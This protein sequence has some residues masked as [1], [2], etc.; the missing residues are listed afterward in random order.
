MKSSI[1]TSFH[2]RSR[3]AAGLIL[4]A[5]ALAACSSA[6]F[7]GPSLALDVQSAVS[8]GTVNVHVI[9]GTAV[10]TGRV[11]SRYDAQAAVRT[12][13]RHEEVQRVV[14]HLYIARLR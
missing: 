10:L 5:S 2:H 9:D 7:R 8:S 12:A 1:I 13:L 6:N 14:D 11:R 3:I 4:V